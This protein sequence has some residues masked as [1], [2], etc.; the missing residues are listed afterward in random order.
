MQMRARHT[1]QDHDGVDNPHDLQ[2][3]R[4]RAATYTITG[5]APDDTP[6]ITTLPAPLGRGVDRLAANTPEYAERMRTWRLKRLAP[7]SGVDERRSR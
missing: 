2:R 3:R 4:A 1:L 7:G 5:V 6:K